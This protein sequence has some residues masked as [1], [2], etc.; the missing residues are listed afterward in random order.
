MERGREPLSEAGQRG[1][2]LP[3]LRDVFPSPN[4]SLTLRNFPQPG[5]AQSARQ[6]LL[7]GDRESTTNNRRETRLRKVFCDFGEVGECREIGCRTRLVCGTLCLPGEQKFAVDWLYSDCQKD[8]CCAIHTFC[9]SW[10]VTD[11]AQQNHEK[12][13][14][15][16]PHPTPP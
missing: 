15:P 11:K 8:D 16:N 7:C 1:K 14:H 9:P 12:T 13:P 3:S 2:P 6:V 5:F 4:L 10:I